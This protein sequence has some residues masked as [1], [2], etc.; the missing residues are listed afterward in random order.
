MK[1]FQKMKN[2]AIVY[3]DKILLNR[4]QNIA[5]IFI[6]N[7]SVFISSL[8]VLQIWWD[9]QNLNLTRHFKGESFYTFWP[10][11]S[12]VMILSNLSGYLNCLLK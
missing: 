1:L 4:S 6:Y 12:Q 3:L 9:N 7:I 8:T 2:S 5:L 10:I 11:F